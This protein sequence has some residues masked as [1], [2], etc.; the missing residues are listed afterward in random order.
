[1]VIFFWKFD[2]EKPT[3]DI[4]SKLSLYNKSIIVLSVIWISDQ[5]NVSVFPMMKKQIRESF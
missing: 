1:M 2:L 4:L 3:W 5:H